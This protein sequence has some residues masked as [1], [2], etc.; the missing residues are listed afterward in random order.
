[1]L[2]EFSYHDQVLSFDTMGL[3]FNKSI[4][5]S[6]YSK[7][8]MHFTPKLLTV[9]AQPH[10]TAQNAGC[11]PS[12]MRSCRGLRVLPLPGITGDDEPGKRSKSTH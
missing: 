6:K 10:S 11:F 9:T 8:K 4:G 2:A 5:S 1:M 7:G 12:W 3:H